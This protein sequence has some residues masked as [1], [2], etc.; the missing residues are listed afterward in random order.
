[1]IANYDYYGFKITAEILPE[2]CTA[3]P[4]WAVF[5]DAL[6]TG[7]CIITGH[8]IEIDGQQDNG[9]MNDCPIIGSESKENE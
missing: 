7:I 6:E 9:R 2:A 8:E 5:T 1:M 4:F 3:C